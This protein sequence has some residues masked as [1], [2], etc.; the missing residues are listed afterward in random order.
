M[1]IVGQLLGGL[2][3]IHLFWV[4]F[5]I[6]GTL[7]KARQESSSDHD[8]PCQPAPSFMAD[9]VITTATGMAI[10]GFVVMLFGFL[11]I[12]NK[13]A[14]LVWLLTEG[15]LFKVVGN[16][17]V[18]SAAF[19]L[20]RF[21]LIKRAWSLP[22]LLIYCGF[23]IISVPAILPPTLWDSIMYHLAYAVD[24]ANEG[25]IYVDEFLRFPYY[26]NNFLL[27]YSMLFALKLGSACH[28]L[29][30]LCGLLTGLGVYS[31]IAQEPALSPDK[32]KSTH[33]ITLSALTIIL[34]LTLSPVFLRY[35]NTGYVDIPIG[36][37][38]L[39]AVLCVYIGLRGK[40]RRYEVEFVLIAAFCVGMKI[41]LTL[42]LP[43]FI[44][45]LVILLMKE[46]QPPSRIIGLVSLML[47]L[48]APWYVRNFI[49][50]GD[51]IS[52]TLNIM[53]H[54][55]DAIWTPADYATQLA[56]LKTAKDPLSL[57]RLP[58]DLFWNTPSINFREHGTSPVVM[59]LYVPFVMAVLLL[60]SK[61]RRRF[62]GPFVYLNVALLYSLVYWIGISSFARYFLHLFPL[63]TVYIGVWL[64][65]LL[66][67]SPFTQDANRAHRPVNL[68]ITVG[69][70][71]L[72]LFP[73]P[74]ARTYY[75]GLVQDNYLRLADRYG[76]YTGFL[77]RNL[78][79]YASVQYIMANLESSGG[80]GE[81]T[82][83]LGCENLSYYFRENR[84]TSIGDWF[85][86]GRHTD[87]LRSVDFNDL[88][89]YLDRFRVRAVLVNLGDKRIDELTYRRFTEQ[90]EENHFVLQPAQ[91]PGTA[92]YIKTK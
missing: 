50:T 79:G 5:F 41:T 36:L 13:E 31:M 72:M 29:T 91:E 81:K 12:L 9:L 46:R 39:T 77:R 74:S 48:S 58:F 86:P 35:V 66:P 38:L 82:L 61:V 45:S 54:R 7:V 8:E 37:F 28:F 52:P 34:G 47:I 15:I 73:T 67:T 70:T 1:F 25:Q 56:D 18:F 84:L 68:F 23:L 60:F 33:L 2:A 24:W 85:G 42:F 87:L 57:L 88:S 3:C 83:L 71:S 76:S 27:C 80:Q 49:K 14:F 51:P 89:S 62:A 69:L 78:T 30:W 65:T 22:S 19:W 20:A 64:N 59:L 55:R 16:E 11:G 44:A 43:L 53:F 75:Q 21:K 4:Y 32:S 63:Y 26:A 17:N 6:T 40:A 10:T 92:I 90:L